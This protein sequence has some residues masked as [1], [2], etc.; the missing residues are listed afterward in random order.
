MKYTDFRTSPRDESM[1]E[2][3]KGANGAAWATE[4]TRVRARVQQKIEA[5]KEYAA[6][7]SPPQGVGEVRVVAVL[8]LGCGATAVDND[9]HRAVPGCCLQAMS[10]RSK[11]SSLSAPATT[12]L[13]KSP[14]VVPGHEARHSLPAA[15]RPGVGASIALGGTS[16]DVGSPGLPRRLMPM[17][18]NSPAQRGDSAFFQAGT[19]PGDGAAGI[20]SSGKR[21]SNINTVKMSSPAPQSTPTRPKQLPFDAR[22][23]GVQAKDSPNRAHRISSASAKKGGMCGEQSVL[24][25][26]P[27]FTRDDLV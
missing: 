8:V 19:S 20:A 27:M 6:K 26:D 7:I 17:A 10:V 21:L 2:G 25:N 22:L 16:D 24:T 5:L 13:D 12:S 11:M 23:S 9:S 3:G 1:L 4:S 14:I 18:T 15:I